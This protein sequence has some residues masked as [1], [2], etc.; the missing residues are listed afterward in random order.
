MWRF[1][2]YAR[3]KAVPLSPLV[4]CPRWSSANRSDYCMRMIERIIFDPRIGASIR[5]VLTARWDTPSCGDQYAQ[6]H[7]RALLL[8]LSEIISRSNLAIAS[9]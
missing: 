4:Q 2:T 9:L 1:S 5:L 7:H 6:N 8:L 3:Q